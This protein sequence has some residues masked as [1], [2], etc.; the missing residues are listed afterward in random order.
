[1]RVNKKHLRNIRF[2]IRTRLIITSKNHFRHVC[3]SPSKQC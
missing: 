1:M 2:P 3:Y